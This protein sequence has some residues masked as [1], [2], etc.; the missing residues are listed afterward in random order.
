VRQQPDATIEE[1]LGDVFSV[2]SVP[3]SYKEANFRVYLV[4]RQSPA[5]KDLN[6]E[7]ER[8]TELKPLLNDNR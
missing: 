3:R 5:S 1:L 6:A 4:V 7:V 8:S 2:R